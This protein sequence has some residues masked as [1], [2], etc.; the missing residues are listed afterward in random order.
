MRPLVSTSE[1]IPPNLN[2]EPDRL[3]SIKE[4]A[5]RLNVAPN[6]VRNAIEGGK[7]LAYLLPGKGRGTYRIPESSVAG[8]LDTHIYRP[9]ERPTESPI[10][11]RGRPL[12]HLALNGG[13][14]R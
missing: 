12:R 6:T 4:V 11:H 2:A 14:G 9:A 1:A 7:L 3:L 10:R 8:Y 5:R 13:E